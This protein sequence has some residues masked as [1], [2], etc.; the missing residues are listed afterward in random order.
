MLFLRFS[1]WLEHPALRYVLAA[2]WPA[3]QGCVLIGFSTGWFWRQDG[4]A[5]VVPA[6][7]LALWFVVGVFGWR[8][9]RVSA[10]LG[11]ARVWLVGHVIA[12]LVV[13]VLNVVVGERWLLVSHGWLP[14]S[15]SLGA[16]GAFYL[17]GSAFVL[18]WTHGFV[19]SA[20]VALRRRPLPRPVEWG[21]GLVLAGWLAVGGVACLL[22]PGFETVPRN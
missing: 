6:V 8:R 12:G 14:P 11:V 4:L 3:A 15:A 19:A 1:V 17:M 2:S 10:A 13:E 20:V 7:P 18:L 16:L 9:A 22:P 5:F 21:F